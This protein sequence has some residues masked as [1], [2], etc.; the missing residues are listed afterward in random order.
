MKFALSLLFATVTARYVPK[1]KRTVDTPA[2]YGLSKSKESDF[3]RDISEDY[4]GYEGATNH[5]RDNQYYTKSKYHELLERAKSKYV[6]PKHE[7]KYEAP[8]K[9]PKRKMN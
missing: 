4:T 1:F 5:Y 9:A 3:A 7:P 6:A 8:K 2:D